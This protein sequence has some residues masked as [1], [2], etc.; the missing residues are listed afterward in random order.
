MIWANGNLKHLRAAEFMDIT[1]VSPLWVEQCREAGRKAPEKDFLI[2]SENV[3]TPPEGAK[4]K[5]PRVSEP[6]P[7]AADALPEPDSPSLNSSKRPSGKSIKAKSPPETKQP[8]KGGQ[9][10]AKTVVSPP[11]PTK[12]KATKSTKSPLG[13]IASDESEGEEEEEKTPTKGRKKTPKKETKK[14]APVAAPP[15]DQ[16]PDCL[17]ALSG[18]EGE[19]RCFL[20]DLIQSIM[21]C[22][23]PTSSS[24]SKQYGLIEE[25]NFS[26]AGVSD[27]THI[28]ASTDPMR[29]P[30]LPPYLPQHLSSSISLLSGDLFVSSLE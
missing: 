15:P 25:N 22:V 26:L 8:S 13:P 28:I 5:P 4:S 14:P 11:P 16:K 3:I 6:T 20:T 17:I 23:H 29:S 9:R 7:D 12:P 1:I 2:T 21:T 30:S 24:S 19:E 10:G 27:C 18:F